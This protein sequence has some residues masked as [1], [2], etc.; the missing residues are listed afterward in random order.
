[1]LFLSYRFVLKE[2]LFLLFNYIFLFGRGLQQNVWS[3]KL[4]SSHTDYFIAFLGLRENKNKDWKRFF[5]YF[6][7]LT[8][9]SQEM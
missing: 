2:Y 7:S 9:G 5:F 3:L 1:M 6:P 8:Q 4:K